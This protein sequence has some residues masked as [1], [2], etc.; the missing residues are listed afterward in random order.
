MIPSFVSRKIGI[1]RVVL[2][3]LS[4]TLGVNTGLVIAVMLGIIDVPLSIRKLLVAVE[5]LLA[6]GLPLL[7]VLKRPILFNLIDDE[8]ERRLSMLSRPLRHY[9]LVDRHY[10]E[11]E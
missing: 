7:S 5:L 11:E 8:I 2:M 1:F 4:L 3:I 9:Y 6:L 10:H